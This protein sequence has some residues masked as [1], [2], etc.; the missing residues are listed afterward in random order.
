[1]TNI[2]CNDLLE[3]LIGLTIEEG[4]KLCT[5]NGYNVRITREDSRNFIIT[6][7]VRFNRINLELDNGIITKCHIG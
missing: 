1:M 5:E 3:S 2:K 4:I 7:D 6:M